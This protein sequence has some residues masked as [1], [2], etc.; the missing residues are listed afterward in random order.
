MPLPKIFNAVVLII[1]TFLLGNTSSRICKSSV[2]EG[3]Y[4]PDYYSNKI[5]YKHN[6]ELLY[7]KPKGNYLIMNHKGSYES[8]PAS[9][10]KLKSYI[11]ASNLTIT[12]NAYE[13]ELL[14]Y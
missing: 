11:A 9:Y 8:L 7:I 4:D 14:S 13:Y 12:G 5:S 10:E 2:E 6:S 3:V 1:I